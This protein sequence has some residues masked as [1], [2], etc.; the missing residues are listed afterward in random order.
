MWEKN[1]AKSKDHWLEVHEPDQKPLG[2]HWWNAVVKWDGCIHLH[3]AG[4]V[5]FR[6]DFGYADGTRDKGACDDYFHIC[7]LDD[8]IARLQAL[9]AAALE[10]FGPDW[11][12]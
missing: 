3:H 5:P 8:L 7:E 1:A 9:K 6:D 4:N 12:R 10:H 11:P 2:G